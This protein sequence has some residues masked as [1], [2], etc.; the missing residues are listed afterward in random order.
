MRILFCVLKSPSASHHAKLSMSHHGGNWPLSNTSR[1]RRYRDSCMAPQQ[2]LA[3]SANTTQVSCPEH[4]GICTALRCEA[5]TSAFAPKGK[6]PSQ[7]SP[8]HKEA[9]SDKDA[10]TPLDLAL[11]NE[12]ATRPCVA[13]RHTAVRSARWSPTPAAGEFAAAKKS[14]DRP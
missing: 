1:P 10:D 6:H 9:V 13:E 12:C 7:P 5:N 4:R 14:R 8:W 3:I 11:Q 2:H